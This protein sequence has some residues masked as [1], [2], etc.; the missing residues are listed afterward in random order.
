MQ[1]VY[2]S[3]FMLYIQLSTS[4]ALLDSMLGYHYINYNITGL[5]NL[6][7]KTFIS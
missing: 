2:R 5:D 4:V 3:S 7:W 6:T 1:A